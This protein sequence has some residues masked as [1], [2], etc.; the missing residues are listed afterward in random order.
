MM[1]IERITVTFYLFIH[2]FILNHILKQVRKSNLAQ[3]QKQQAQVVACAELDWTPSR[4][5]SQDVAAWSRCKFPSAFL[6]VPD[7]SK[8]LL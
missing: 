8:D 2:E 3:Q 6:P 7:L 4:E 1:F 5:I